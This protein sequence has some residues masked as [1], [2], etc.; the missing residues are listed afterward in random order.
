MFVPKMLTQ[1]MNGEFTHFGFKAA[2][3][4]KWRTR[5]LSG[6]PFYCIRKCETTV[7]LFVSLCGIQ[8]FIGTTIKPFFKID[9]SVIAGGTTA[10]G[11]LK[12]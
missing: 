11:V 6:K 9:A 10:I 4:R 8:S 1:Q 7:N 12:T 5:H 2:L 3:A